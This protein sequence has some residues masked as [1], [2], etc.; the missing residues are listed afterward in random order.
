MDGKDVEE[1]PKDPI[2][3]LADEAA[4]DIVDDLVVADGETLA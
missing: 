1:A 4:K 2:G 3:D